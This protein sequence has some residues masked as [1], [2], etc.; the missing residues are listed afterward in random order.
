M[1]L[2]RR[3]DIAKRKGNYKSLQD[4]YDDIGRFLDKLKK[5]LLHNVEHLEDDMVKLWDFVILLFL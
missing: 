1:Y 4:L 3:D 5:N 2:T